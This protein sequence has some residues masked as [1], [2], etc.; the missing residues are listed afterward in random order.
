MI[1]DGRLDVSGTTGHAVAIS[2]LFEPLKAHTRGMVG[3]GGSAFCVAELLENFTTNA[4][5]TFGTWKTTLDSVS[6]KIE[7][8]STD[9]VADGSRARTDGELIFLA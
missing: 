3:V 6:R 1:A 4:A 8:C 9:T 7:T 5:L 2:V